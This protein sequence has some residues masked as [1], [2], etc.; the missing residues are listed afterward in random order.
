[1]AKMIPRGTRVN[2]VQKDK[3]NKKRDFIPPS[4]A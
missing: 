4:A 1:L 2:I 3:W